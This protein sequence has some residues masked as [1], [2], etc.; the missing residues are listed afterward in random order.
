MK[1]D[2][3]QNERQNEDLEEEYSESEDSED[4]E[5][6]KEELNVKIEDNYN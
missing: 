4:E 5:I 6:Y 1:L 2:L 3:H